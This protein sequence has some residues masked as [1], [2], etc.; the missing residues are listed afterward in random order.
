MGPFLLVLYHLLLVKRSFLQNIVNR[1]LLRHRRRSVG[2]HNT[3]H[4][5][6]QGTGESEWMETAK[7]VPR[8]RLALG[9]PFK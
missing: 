5:Y 8:L 4:P 7:Q 3:R 1:F 9:K 2:G 6:R